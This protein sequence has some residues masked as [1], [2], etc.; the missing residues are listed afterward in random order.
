MSA[1][2]QNNQEHPFAGIHPAFQTGIAAASEALS[3]V[4]EIS[5]ENGEILI[6]AKEEGATLSL[7]VNAA[8]KLIST[9]RHSGANNPATA[10]LLDL[11]CHFAIGATVQ[12]VA[13]HGVIHVMGQ[14]QDK[15][16]PRPTS[17]ILTPRNA[18]PIF[19]IPLKLTRL[20]WQ[21]YAEQADAKREQNS[22][23][24][25]FSSSWKEKNDAQKA[26]LV[27]DLLN[28]FR[29]DKKLSKDDLFLHEIDQYDRVVLMFGGA[30][31]VGDKPA[32]LMDL[33][34]MMRR[35]S[36]ERLEVFVEIAEDDNTIRRL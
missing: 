35:A 1:T 21:A 33:E 24:R 9:A 22:F 15:G 27:N 11:L 13:E 26:E 19:H 34:A 20:L 6:S 4:G 16:Q 10:A 12:E 18:D 17:G 23:D 30:V 8:S 29:Q 32:M 14:V 7:S 2:S 36:G 31:P 3:H 25:P 28:T 5:A